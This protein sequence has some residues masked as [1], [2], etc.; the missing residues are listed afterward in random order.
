MNG[1]FLNQAPT[2]KR[3]GFTL[4]ELLVVIAII[5][6]LASMLLPALSQAK[7]KARVAKA[8]T[9]MQG[10]AGAVKA[11]DSTY[12]Q[13]PA[14]RQTRGTIDMEANP[15]F[16]FG[17]I[18]NAGGSQNVLTDSQ[19]RPLPEIGNPGS[20]YQ[21]SNAEVI[22]VLR[23]IEQFPNG[24]ATANQNHQ[25]NPQKEDFLDSVEMA[26]DVGMPGI[27]PDGVYRDPWGHPYIMTFDMNRDNLCIDGFYGQPSVSQKSGSGG[28]NGLNRVDSGSFALRS[29]VMV[30]SF[31][32]DGQV[33]ANVNANQG[34]NQDNVLSWD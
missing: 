6:I 25:L 10:L 32:P 1:K 29:Q 8:R 4:I 28:F 27:G 20:D 16:T 19:G 2:P 21:T 12:N 9:E 18:Y 3:G 23:A 30:W 11:Y 17:T 26:E 34:V 15:D 7:V 31:G 5:G 22:A 14:S 33:N 13:W 24:V